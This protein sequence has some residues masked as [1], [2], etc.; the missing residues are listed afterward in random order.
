MATKKFT[1]TIAASTAAKVAAEKESS[2]LKKQLT[3]LQASS[4]KTIADLQAQLKKANEELAALT[5]NHT[6]LTTAKV[7]ET[8]RRG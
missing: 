8:T 5:K 7:M 1:D 2:D 4:T 3:D 6:E